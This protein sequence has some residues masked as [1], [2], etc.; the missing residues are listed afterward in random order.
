MVS[1][2]VIDDE[3]SIRNSLVN[4][5]EDY[6]FDVES[7][8]S[9]EEALE[10]VLKKQYDVAIVDLRLPG[11]S[12]EAFILKASESCEKLQ[13]LIHTGSVDYRISESLISIGMTSKHLLLKPLADLS[14]LVDAISWLINKKTD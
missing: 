1:I 6:D 3:P 4:Y 12:G 13:Y 8:E 11:M 5:L 9:G 2:L 7:A 14:L 10:L